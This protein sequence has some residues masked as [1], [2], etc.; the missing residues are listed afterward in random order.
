MA[1]LLPTRGKADQG[2]GILRT[3]S[4]RG[5]FAGRRRGNQ[6]GRSASEKSIHEADSLFRKD[7]YR[8]VPSLLGFYPRFDR[9][10]PECIC[11]ISPDYRRGP[12]SRRIAAS[13]LP[14]INRPIKIRHD[15]IL[16]LHLSQE[17]VAAFRKPGSS[18]YG[19]GNEPW[20]CTEDSF[21][22]V[23]LVWTPGAGRLQQFRVFRV[24]GGREVRY[25]RGGKLCNNC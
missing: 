11:R 9:G 15:S 14:T 12:S 16:Y 10:I 20:Q 22:C 24:P 2:S 18:A 21:L 5:A 8:S 7:G 1:A 17:S 25:G 23:R 19:S 13:N 3:K 6:P 4:I